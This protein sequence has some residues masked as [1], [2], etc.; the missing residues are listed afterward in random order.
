[1]SAQSPIHNRETW[2]WRRLRVT[3]PREW[4]MLQFARNSREGRCAFADRYRFCLE[5]DWRVVPG[6][7]EF[8]RMLQDLGSRLEAQHDGFNARQVECA[9]WRGIVGQQRDLTVS[10]YGRYFEEE[11]CLLEAVFLW[12]E[13]TVDAAMEEEILRGIAYVPPVGGMARWRAFGMD[14]RVPEGAGLSEC[15]VRP[16]DVELVFTCP[17]S[18]DI[19]FARRGMVKHWLTSGVEEWLRTQ[20]PRTTVVSGGWTRDVCGHALTAVAGTAKPDGVFGPI[21]PRRA[22]EA[23]AWICPRDGRLYSLVWEGK[24]NDAGGTLACCPDIEA[25]NGVE[26]PRN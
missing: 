1:M 26:T 16:G 8:D 7:P 4:T 2:I 22:V 17:G 12:P 20:V 11:S 21:R 18:A 6:A 15:R 13:H 24:T 19:R 10:R 25:D 14:M 5:V 9:G 3:L 23:R